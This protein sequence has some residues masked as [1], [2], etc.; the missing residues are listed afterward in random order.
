MPVVY[1]KNAH[2]DVP[3]SLRKN[4]DLAALDRGRGAVASKAFIQWLVDTAR[5]Q[6]APAWLDHVEESRN[7]TSCFPGPE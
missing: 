7:H 1:F 6:R 3:S 4:G 5:T 2:G